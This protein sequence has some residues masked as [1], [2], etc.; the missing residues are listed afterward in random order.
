MAA[1]QQLLK[2]Y[3]LPQQSSSK[4]SSLNNSFGNTPQ[5][6]LSGGM[7]ILIGKEVIFLAKEDRSEDLSLE[8]KLLPS[9]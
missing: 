2:M 6:N 9:K 4:V 1:F 8:C 7:N 3:Q 5:T